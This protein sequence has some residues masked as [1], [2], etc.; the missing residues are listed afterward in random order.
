MSLTSLEHEFIAACC[1]APPDF[2][3]AKALLAAGVDINGKDDQGEPFVA[4]IVFGY[5]QTAE[6]CCEECEKC[7]KYRGTTP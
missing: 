4:E 5:P 3:K 6:I 2:E 1:E 7:E